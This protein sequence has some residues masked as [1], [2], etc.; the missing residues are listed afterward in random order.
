EADVLTLGRLIRPD[1]GGQP[2]RDDVEVAER[3]GEPEVPLRRR[4][5]DALDV[6]RL[7]RVVLAD[8]AGRRV[9]VLAAR[10]AVDDLRAPVVR[11]AS[12]PVEVRGDVQLEVVER[13]VEGGPMLR[14]SHA[15]DDHVALGEHTI[16]VADLLD[17]YRAQLDV[18]GNRREV[19]AAA[20]GPRNEAVDDPHTVT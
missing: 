1:A 17:P 14:P 15:V 6:A 20:R 3:R 18:R 13:V 16:E 12:Q 19:L 4:L 2:E 7:L 10:A 8:V 5:V 11:Y 9:G